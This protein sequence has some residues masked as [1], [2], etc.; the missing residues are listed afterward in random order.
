MRSSAECLALAEG[1]EAK[2]KTDPSQRQA[3]LAV[4][5]QW[6]VLAAQANR[7]GFKLTDVTVR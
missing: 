1:L 5:D 3:L 7:F 2:A 6:R 4:A